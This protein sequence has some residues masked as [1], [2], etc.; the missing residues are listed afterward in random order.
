[1]VVDPFFA[2]LIDDVSMVVIVGTF[3]KPR[4]NPFA[5]SI[6]L[7]IGCCDDPII[8]DEVPRRK[9]VH[10]PVE[11]WRNKRHKKR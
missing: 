3:N 10:H 1:M 5:H 4:H 7:M 2:D 11:D 6:P 8:M 9:R